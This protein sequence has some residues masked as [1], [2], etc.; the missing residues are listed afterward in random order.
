M[1]VAR[2]SS[3]AADTTT[4]N[5][6]CTDASSSQAELKDRTGS[7]AQ[8]TTVRHQEAM[9]LRPEA[10]LP[11]SRMAEATLRVV[12][13]AITRSKGPDITLHSKEATTRGRE[14]AAST[15]DP[16]QDMALRVSKATPK[17]ILLLERRRHPPPLRVLLERQR[18]MKMVQQLG[19]AS[20]HRV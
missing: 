4:W 18:R 9:V 2:N 12:L 1:T 11:S 7:L 16:I 10:S 13:E 14:E 20:Q 8:G 19:R 17:A 6:K 3:T 15:L 5:R